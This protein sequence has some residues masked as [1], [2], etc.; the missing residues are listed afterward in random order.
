MWPGGVLGAGR[1]AIDLGLARHRRVLADG[2]VWRPL[3]AKSPAAM[4]R[5]SHV[6]SV[7]H[8]DRISVRQNNSFGSSARRGGP[9]HNYPF[10]GRT[11]IREGAR[12]KS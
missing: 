3:G 4:G 2:A 12:L 5:L 9:R 11:D 7:V 1:A 8:K 6:A 10:I